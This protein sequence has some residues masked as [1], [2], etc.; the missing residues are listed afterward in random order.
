VGSELAPRK[1]GGAINREW[2]LS[3]YKERSVSLRFCRFATVPS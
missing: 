3:T 1:K 2:K